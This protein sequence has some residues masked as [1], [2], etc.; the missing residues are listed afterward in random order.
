MDNIHPLSDPIDASTADIG[1]LLV[2]H[3]TRKSSGQDQ[4]RTVYQQFKG[5][6]AP[7]PTE[8]AFLELAEPDIPAGIANLA[9]KGVKR[10]VTV[11]VLLFT[12]GHAIEDIPNAVK[13]ACAGPQI[14]PLLQT[15]AFESA[16]PLLRLSQLRFQQAACTPSCRPAAAGEALNFSGDSD[17]PQKSGPSPECLS[18]VRSDPGLFCDSTALLMIGRGSNSESATAKM[19]EFTA[20]RRV[21]TPVAWSE[22]AF[23]HA[24]SPSVDEGLDRLESAPQ[25]L[26]VVQPHLLFDGL[27]MDQLRRQIAERSA[28]DP[29]NKWVLTDVLGTDEELARTLAT[30]A[31]SAALAHQP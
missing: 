29:R 3:G 1:F 17:P 2:G 27:L 14:T 8:L 19:R 24:Q 12:A 21:L 15:G 26:K 11:P 20:N 13:E 9:A 31:K 7:W 18:C 28:R 5:F 30:L 23:I 6:M 22:T 10:L 25:R 4:F 16:E